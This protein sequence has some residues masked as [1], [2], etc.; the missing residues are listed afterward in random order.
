M[1]E[2]G[3][4]SRKQCVFGQCRN[5]KCICD[6]GVTGSRCN[7][8]I[9]DCDVGSCLNNG[10]MSSSCQWCCF[11]WQFLQGTCIELINGFICRCQRGFT[12]PRCKDRSCSSNFISNTC[13]NRSTSIK[14]CSVVKF[15]RDSHERI[16]VSLNSN[17][18]RDIQCQCE[19]EKEDKRWISCQLSPSLYS[20]KLLMIGGKSTTFSSNF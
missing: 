2:L 8:D 20:G 15:S 16:C 5:D 9:I 11:Q 18:L 7:T 12:G 13:L 4:C 10:K 17:S 19:Y 3:E 1:N 6:A 14:P